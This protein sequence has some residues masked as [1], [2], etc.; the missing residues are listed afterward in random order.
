MEGWSNSWKGLVH[1]YTHCHLVHGSYEMVTLELSE[2]VTLEMLY[3]S[4]LDCA[5]VKLC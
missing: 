4:L 2:K 5:C 3:S 1:Y